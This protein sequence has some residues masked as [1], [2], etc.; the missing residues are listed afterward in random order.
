M[1]N[2]PIRIVLTLFTLAVFGGIAQGQSPGG[3][4]VL[5]DID[6]VYSLADS[7]EYVVDETKTSDA[8]RIAIRSFQPFPTSS[9]QV[10]RQGRL[11]LRASVRNETASSLWV[12]QNGQNVESI[13]LYRSTDDG[14][15][16][17]ST[18]G[19]S[20]AFRDRS[21]KNRYPTFRI[22]LPPGESRV[23]L[24]RVHDFQSSNVQLRLFEA[25]QF[26]DSLVGKNLLIGAAF[27]FFAALIVYNSI[28]YLI[29]RD[30]NYLLYAV[31]MGAFFLNQF[32]QERLFARYLAPGVP[33]GFFWFVIFGGSTAVFG[34]LFLRHF[35]ETP[36]RMPILDRTMLVVAALTVVL[37][38]STVFGAG[39]THADIL[40]GLSLIVMALTVTAMVRRIA[41]GYFP[42]VACLLGS[43]IYFAGTTVEIVSTFVPIPMTAVV[44]HSQLFGAL[45]QVLILSLALGQ[46]TKLLQENYEQMRTA[47]TR[48]L[49]DEVRRRTVELEEANRRLGLHAVTDPLTGLYNRAELENRVSE[50]ETFGSR[51]DQSPSDQPRGWT[52]LS[53]A[54]LDLDNFKYYNDQFGHSAGDEILKSVANRLLSSVRGYD[55]VFRVGGD[56]FVVMMPETNMV[57]ARSVAERIRRELCD[58]TLVPQSVVGSAEESIEIPPDKRLSC[59][60]GIATGLP[61]S[62]QNVDRLIRQADDALLQAKQIGKNCVASAPDNN[63]NDLYADSGS[64]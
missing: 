56:E 31:Y 52:Q 30:L 39:P 22:E 36:Q 12:I 46:K 4:T 53:V 42:A 41:E 48:S 57:Q 63:A 29:N 23:L 3:P 16:L 15:E 40:N 18:T 11:W 38:G 60:I 61:D 37:M 58:H 33:Y 17:V 64:A 51:L 55:V 6:S 9:I 20:V 45:A 49:E 43:L 21:V 27:G 5:E 44:R 50:R 14:F 32:A 1:S 28:V 26:M 10:P 13:T 8:N 47:F 59:S 35:L 7:L 62:D 19:N 34:V 54:Y 25:G 24:F 2:K